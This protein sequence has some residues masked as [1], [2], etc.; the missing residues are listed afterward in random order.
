M[1][2]Q[3]QR[4][5]GNTA[6]NDAFLGALGELA[7][8]TE[9]IGLRLHDGVT[10]GG[11]RIAMFSDIVSPPFSDSTNLM[12]GSTD[13]TKLLR[14]EVDGFTAATTRVLTPQNADYIIA[15]TNVSNT[16]SVNQSFSGQVLL[17]A[18]SA[19][20]P[21]LGFSA[22]PSSGIFD[23]GSGQ[24]AMN[25]A[26]S[27]AY[28]FAGTFFQIIG[29]RPLSFGVTFGAPDL[30]VLRD[31][32]NILAMRNGVNA[33][34]FRVY[35]TFTDASNYERGFFG[36]NS[37][38]LDIGPQAAGTGTLRSIGLL[39]HVLFPTDNTFD[40]GASGATRPRNL[41]LGG[42]I[43][44]ATFFTAA[45]VAASMTSTGRWQWTARAAMLSPADG[46]ILFQNNALNDFNRLQFGGTTSSFPSLKRSTTGLQFRLADDSAYTFADALEYRASGTK[47]VGAQGA[48]VA[49]AA[50]GATVDAEARTAIN[51]LLA[52]LRTHG[53]IAT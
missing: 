6:Q 27:T 25:S 23:A 44:C 26:G 15:G 5:R 39:S 37:N 41:F 47:V 38:R 9:L 21:S 8:N 48:A 4:R 12:K 42:E 50:G 18:G 52:R 14:F 30:F 36:W 19:A 1:A 10:V 32:A 28:Y 46:V 20:L 31:A 22:S 7:F 2:T 53:L 45:A 51:T 43:S 34:A 40:I 49:D 29:V 17:A 11:H 13:P 24:P 3:V 35:N 33:Q 16:F